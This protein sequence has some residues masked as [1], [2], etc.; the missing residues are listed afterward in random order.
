MKIFSSKKRVAVIGA[1]TA[2]T[3]VGGGTAFAYWTTSGSGTGSATTSAGAPALTI[4]GDAP[5]AMFPGDSPQPLVVTVLNNAANSARVA[6]VTAVVS[7]NVSGCTGSDF[8]INDTPAGSAVTLN[9][10][11]VDLAP[12]GSQS[13]PSSLVTPGSNSIQFNNKPSDSQ[14]PCKAID[15]ITKKITIT[16]TAN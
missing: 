16:Y 7:T 6:G 1:L 15:G 5:D 2:V 3:L 8:K 4:T 13:T 9:W 11:A 12:G 14:D 10:T